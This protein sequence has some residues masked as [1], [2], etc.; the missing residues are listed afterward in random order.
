MVSSFKII[1]NQSTSAITVE[2]IYNQFSD[3]LKNSEYG[4]HLKRDVDDKIVSEK[5]LENPPYTVGMKFPNFELLDN[6]DKLIKGNN[7][8]GKYTLI[9]FWA[10]WCGPCRQ[11]TPN[12]IFANSKFKE[13]GFRVITIS[14]DENSAQKKWLEVIG[15][16]KMSAFINLFNGN[17]KS[18]LAKELKIVAI[19]ANFLVDSTGRIVATNLRGEQLQIK[20][21]E[22][23]Q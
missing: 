17:D 18:G 15:S 12:L 7:V 21:R 10:T 8:F 1:I 14:I 3:R 16:D 6:Q 2:N 11:E 19:P 9:D 5:K 13:K 4:I 20:L 22:L 23:M